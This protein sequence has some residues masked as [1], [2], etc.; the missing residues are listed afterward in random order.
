MI[1][2]CLRTNFFYHICENITKTS[3]SSIGKTVKIRRYINGFVG[4]VTDFAKGQ[5]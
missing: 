4:I 1:S 2:Y 3:E 5:K